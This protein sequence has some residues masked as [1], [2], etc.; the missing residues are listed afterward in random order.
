MDY[1]S[2]RNKILE[3]LKADLL[4]GRREREVS[5]L[6]RKFKL[7]TLNEDEESWAD[8][9]IRPTSTMALLST[10]KAP[11]LAASILEID[12]QPIGS[13]FDYP[14]DMPKEVKS[15][16]DASQLQRTYWVREQM[17]MFLAEDS[18]RKFINT[19]YDA[20]EEMLRERDE[21]ME[22]LPN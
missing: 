16:L 19:L 17:L 15:A 18:N 5:V 20:Y 14:E 6:G 11:T 13:L 9:Y 22:K 4:K 8:T 3:D 12:G 21:A 1:K 7:H 10:K 2:K